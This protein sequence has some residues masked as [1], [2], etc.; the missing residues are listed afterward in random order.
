[1]PSDL[2]FISNPFALVVTGR[3]FA[4]AV[5]VLSWMVLATPASA[6]SASL[7]SITQREI[8]RRESL[9]KTAEAQLGESQILMDKGEPEQAARSLMNAYES[10]P[11]VPVTA[12]IRARLRAAY[13]T[14][15]CALARKQLSEGR[16]AEAS[17]TLETVLDEDVDPQNKEALKL[18]KQAADP[19]RYPP[20]LTPRH[21][22]DTKEVTRLL[23]L[24]GS[25]MDLG[26]PD[27]ALTAYQDVLRLDA[28]NTAAR[29][30]L[31][32][33]EQFKSRYLQSARDHTR[34]HMLETVNSLWEE[35]VPASDK[36]TAMFSSSG[37]GGNV[38]TGGREV[39]ER[40]LRE[41]KI[42]HVEFNNASLDEV[43]EYLRVTS[44]NID[45]DGRG[46]DFIV[47]LEPEARNR[48]LSL[49]LSNLPLEEVLRYVTQIAEATYRVEATAVVIGSLTERSTTLLTKVYKVPPDF[50]QTAAV[51]P[52]GDAAGGADPFAKKAGGSADAGVATGLQVRRM[53]AREF[54]EGRGISF[55]DGATASFSGGSSTL[56]VH[57]TADNLNLVDTLVESA[58]AN[59]AK[60]AV[61]SV[62]MLDVSQTRLNELGFDWELGQ[63]NVPGS[64]KVFA[65]GG[66]VGNQGSADAFQAGMPG[67]GNVASTLMTAGLRS[68]GEILGKP[69]IEGLLASNGSTSGSAVS[70][71]S[72]SPAQLALLG[73][74]TDPQ[75][76]T[77]V[78]SLSQSKGVDL[79]AAPMITAK[80]GQKSSVRVVRE[81]PYPTEFDPPQIPQNF[82][83]GSSG[84][85]LILINAN[86]LV[87]SN[88]GGSGAMPITPTT[89]TAF[90]TK[91]VGIILEVEPVISGDGRT[92]E[93][94]LTP[95]D[96][97]FEGFI[98]YGSPI[99]TSGHGSR[100]DLNLFAFV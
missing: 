20:A 76:Q 7:Q 22:A 61:I 83:G 88:A 26:N 100:L 51:D 94:S 30:G 82:G 17:K 11:E 91:E 70:A 24:A 9:V 67:G 25:F 93:L 63:F 87:T 98:D 80:S 40:K 45:P 28:Y 1:M 73:V 75:F 57:N 52:A 50:I 19:D 89:P 66:G 78:R 65:S 71:D 15:A 47:H 92:V 21:I 8:Q 81:F 35:A 3:R 79:V 43:I 12:D 72:R 56:V 38:A 14:A 48:Q 68:S 62:K 13:S 36:L 69:G 54:L 18:R 59:G 99:T 64:N 4:L 53:G 60:Q 58:L 46:V 5:G 16:Y 96:I 42:P 31:E 85:T 84:G 27:K 32:K 41:L 33:V 97:E 55:P 6:Q 74:F 10:L 90:A 49:A 77:A 23:T 34:S 44:R 2:S 95:S 86:G 29:R 39:I 37:G